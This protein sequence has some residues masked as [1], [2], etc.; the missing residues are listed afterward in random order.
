M[1]FYSNYT[2]KKL[3]ISTATPASDICRIIPVR[4]HAGYMFCY[5]FVFGYIFLSKK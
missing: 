4:T 3:Q 2:T 5:F 1:L